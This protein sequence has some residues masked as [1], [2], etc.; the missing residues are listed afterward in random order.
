MEGLLGW[1]AAHLVAVVGTHPLALFQARSMSFGLAMK[2]KQGEWC[3]IEHH[4]YAV[5][6]EGV[7]SRVVGAMGV[8]IATVLLCN[9]WL[10]LEPPC[11]LARTLAMAALVGAFRAPGES[12][13]LAVQ[14]PLLVVPWHRGLAW[15]MLREMLF[16]SFFTATA[17]SAQW[18]WAAT[19][20]FALFRLVVLTILS[21]PL[22]HVRLRAM[23]RSLHRTLDV[24][25]LA[26]DDLLFDAPGSPAAPASPSSSWLRSM[27]LWPWL[28]FER[29]IFSPAGLPARLLYNVLLHLI[30]IIWAFFLKA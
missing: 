2:K 18:W 8:A 20:A 28:V 4:G 11:G 26:E 27:T 6:Y 15:V 16:W 22:E 7:S 5:F 14:W 3:F 19:L 25:L 29:A 23:C 13:A 30:T 12:Q 1:A 10:L 17:T 9:V 24:G 21:H